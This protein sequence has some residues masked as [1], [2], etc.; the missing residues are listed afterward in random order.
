MVG[1]FPGSLFFRL[2][3]HVPCL[4]QFISTCVLLKKCWFFRFRFFKETSLRFLQ[5][6]PILITSCFRFMVY[7]VSFL[8]LFS[9][10]SD[11][12]REYAFFWGHYFLRL[13]TFGEYLLKGLCYQPSVFYYLF[14][15]VTPFR[16]SLLSELCCKLFLNITASFYVLMIYWKES[17][18]CWVADKCTVIDW[19]QVTV[20]QCL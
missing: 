13:F 15:M 11:L 7:K 12:I 4:E 6:S 2:L 14:Q 19:F 5:S 18:S 9:L 17:C 8:G 1:N 3:K 16:G 20:E 10:T